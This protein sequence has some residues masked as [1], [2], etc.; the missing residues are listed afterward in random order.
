MSSTS[1]CAGRASLGGAATGGPIRRWRPVGIGGLLEGRKAAGV[2]PMDPFVR[3]A[4][5]AAHTVGRL[6]HRPPARD[7]GDHPIFSMTTKWGELGDS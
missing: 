6:D 2:E 4:Q 3:H 5:V 1:G 7:L